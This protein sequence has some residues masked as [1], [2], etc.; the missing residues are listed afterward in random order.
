MN[1]VII[2]LGIVVDW[3]VDDGDCGQDVVSSGEFK[4]LIIFFFKFQPAI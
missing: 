2:G 3:V 4:A 1:M